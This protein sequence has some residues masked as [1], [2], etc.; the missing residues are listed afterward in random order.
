MTGE[1]LSVLDVETGRS[2]YDDGGPARRYA[3]SEGI[4]LDQRVDAGLPPRLT[5][6]WRKR[7]RG[8]EP[9]AVWS[10]SP[11]AQQQ[12]RFQGFL[13]ADAS[14]EIKLYPAVKLSE[15]PGPPQA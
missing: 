9:A 1:G 7:Q 5:P 15:L 3:L 4:K 12:D 8:R 11:L 2:R 13:V 10:A 14:T 6:T